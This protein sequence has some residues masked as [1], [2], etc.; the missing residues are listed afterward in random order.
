MFLQAVVAV[1]GRKNSN[2]ITQPISD[3]L[4]V[5]SLN[6]NNKLFLALVE[7]SIEGVEKLVR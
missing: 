3:C 1:C 7:I 2:H 4:Y 6:L 5:T